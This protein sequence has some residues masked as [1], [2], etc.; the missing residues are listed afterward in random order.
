[1]TGV[2]FAQGK[3]DAVEKATLLRMRAASARDFVVEPGGQSGR[4]SQS[5]SFLSSKNGRSGLLEHLLFWLLV[6][7]QCSHAGRMSVSVKR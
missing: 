6:P 7:R 5:G 2:A 4:G 1:M 3:W